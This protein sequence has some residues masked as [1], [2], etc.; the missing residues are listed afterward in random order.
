MTHFYFRRIRKQKK[1]IVVLYIPARGYKDRTLLTMSEAE[2]YG[3]ALADLKKVFPKVEEKIVGYRLHRF[4]RAYP[5]MTRGA[6][7]KEFC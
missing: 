6:Y 3:R 4:P 1:Y 7:G 2:I 5:V